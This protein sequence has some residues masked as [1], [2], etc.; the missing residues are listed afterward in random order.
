MRVAQ[1][2]R[3]SDEQHGAPAPEGREAWL[4]EAKSIDELWDG[5][6]SPLWAVH[7]AFH[8]ER[9]FRRIMD[10]GTEALAAAL[11]GYY[12]ELPQ[13]FD[14]RSMLPKPRP[15]QDY[16]PWRE[17]SSEDLAEGMVRFQGAA[18]DLVSELAAEAQFD[19]G[20]PYRDFAT[21]PQDTAPRLHRLVGVTH[22]FGAAMHATEL[23]PAKGPMCEALGVSLAHAFSARPSGA[24]AM[25][26]TLVAALRES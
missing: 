16:F 22:W 24:A 7:V 25:L 15:L 6:R 17:Q 26:T 3:R 14:N 20:S 8:V 23:S 5:T 1:S 18:A 13:L 10:A 4:Q 11:D 9:P 21:W 19:T 2:L 12:D